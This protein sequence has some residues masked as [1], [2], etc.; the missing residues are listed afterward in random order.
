MSECTCEYPD[1]DES[2]D[3]WIICMNCGYEEYIG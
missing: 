3:D 1:W 2:N